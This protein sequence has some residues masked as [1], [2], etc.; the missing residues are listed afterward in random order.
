[1]QQKIS[2]L[3]NE[4]VNNIVNVIFGR[5]MHSKRMTSLAKVVKELIN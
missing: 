1:M 2:T 5:N 4:K 3:N